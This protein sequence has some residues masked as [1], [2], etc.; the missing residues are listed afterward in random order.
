MILIS[1]VKRHG[2][3]VLECIF[4][5]CLIRLLLLR[6]IVLFPTLQK[7]PHLN[8][9]P[10]LVGPTPPTCSATSTSLQRAA[11]SCAPLR[12]SA[13]AATSV[14]QRPQQPQ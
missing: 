11:G 4:C 13:T 14:P 5:L 1:G 8:P 2:I 3:S 7:H 9:I 6:F 12:T 10:L